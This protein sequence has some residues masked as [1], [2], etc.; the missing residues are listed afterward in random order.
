MPAARATMPQRHTAMVGSPRK[1]TSVAAMETD[2]HRRGQHE[3]QPGARRH[4]LGQQPPGEKHHAALATRR[5]RAQGQPNSVAG[6]RPLGRYRSTFSRARTPRPG[7]RPPSRAAKTA[8]PR[9][10]WRG[11]P[12][13][14][15]RDWPG[16]ASGRASGR[17]GQ[18]RFQTVGRPC[19]CPVGT[20]RMI[21]W[22]KRDKAGRWAMLTSPVSGRRSRSR[23]NSAAL[24]LRP[25]RRWPRRQT[26]S[27]V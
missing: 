22:W 1:A 8:R 20:N 5:G 25:G 13:R 11:T 7:P 23:A 21:C 27:A 4:A 6:K 10:R 18:G 24:R 17:G 14:T 2:D 19:G 15:G 12:G 3:G 9:T 16:W 26:T